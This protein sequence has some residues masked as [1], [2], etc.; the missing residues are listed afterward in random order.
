[1]HPLLLLAA[2]SSQITFN[3]VQQGEITTIT[4]QVVLTQAC[5]CQVQVSAMRSGDAGQSTT[6]QRNTF[7]FMANQPQQLSRLSMNIG[8]HDS[9]NIVVTVSDGDA[10]LLSG[11]W[12]PESK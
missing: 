2:L 3:T 9:V 12:S 7:R 10:V 5:E 8:P 4:P 1:M 6:Q 11:Q